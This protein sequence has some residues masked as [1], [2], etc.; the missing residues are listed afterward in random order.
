MEDKKENKPI[1]IRACKR[2]ADKLNVGTQSVVPVGE[3]SIHVGIC[4]FCA[5]YETLLLCEYTIKE[6]EQV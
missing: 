6:Y 4:Q 3:D 2:C 1:H 5:Q